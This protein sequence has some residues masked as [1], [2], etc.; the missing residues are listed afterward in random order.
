MW[1][2]NVI[3]EQF[4]LVALLQIKQ[5]MLPIMPAIIIPGRTTTNRKYIKS[6]PI[7]KLTE[8]RSKAQGFQA[9]NVSY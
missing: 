6:H 5:K 8:V 4:H 1:E 3:K 7:L 2:N 9:F